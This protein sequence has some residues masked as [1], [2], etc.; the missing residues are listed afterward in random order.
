[1]VSEEENGKENEGRQ[2]PV[3]AVCQKATEHG[4]QQTEGKEKEAPGK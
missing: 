4:V 3:T 2:A 1:V